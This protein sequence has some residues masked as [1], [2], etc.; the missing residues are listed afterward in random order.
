MASW[1]PMARFSNKFQCVHI[2]LSWRNEG[3]RVTLRWDN[4]DAANEVTFRFFSIPLEP[5][6]AHYIN[7]SVQRVCA[8]GTMTQVGATFKFTLVQMI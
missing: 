7:H 5:G 3:D 4:G 6:P 8:P 1:Q 2:G